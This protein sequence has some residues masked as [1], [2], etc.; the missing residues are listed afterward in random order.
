MTVERTT[1]K[2]EWYEGRLVSAKFM[3]PDLLAYVGDVELPNFYETPR[4]AIAAGKRYIDEENKE[5]K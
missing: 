5:A 2:S 3:G 1:V 4:A